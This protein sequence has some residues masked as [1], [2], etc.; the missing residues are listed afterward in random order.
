M[1]GIE[2]LDRQLLDAGSVVG[3]L[4]PE[5]SVHQFLADHRQD[6]FPDMMFEDLFRSPRGRPSVPGSVVATVM[7]L[8][9]LEGLSDR[10]ALGRL[11]WDLR[12]KVAAGLGLCDRGFHHTVLTLWRGKLRKSGTPE[13][14]FDAVRGVINETG[15]LSGRT[16]RVLDST[17][18]DDAVAT[19]DTVTMITAGVRK[20]LRLV[21]AARE[22]SL[23]HGYET[24][25]KP[26]CDWDDPESRSRLVNGLVS[27]GLAVLEAAQDTVL[28]SEQADAV[29]LLGVVVGQDVEPDPD[30]EGKWR[31]TRGVAADRTISV[32]DP[33]SRHGRKTSSQKR[34]GYKAH[35]A[36]EPDTGIITACEITPANVPDGPVGTDL[37]AEEPHSVEVIADSAYGSGENRARLEKAGHTTTVKPRPAYRNPRLGPDQFDR[38]RFVVDPE[39]NRVTCPAGNTVGISPRGQAKFGTVCTECVF[40]SRCTT[41]RGG[42]SFHVGPHYRLL[43]EARQKWKQPETVDRYNRHRPSVERIISWIV[44]RGNRKLRHR[45]IIGNRQQ[46][47]TRAA[48]L[49]LRRLINHSYL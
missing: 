39:R 33:S 47:H 38:D 6:V 35:I 32:V 2:R 41:N 4:V 13:R 9:A 24:G 22:V 14:I 28:N 20:V 43:E 49:N 44:A 11:R 42:R 40:R 45:G 15:L 3:D 26:G 23:S 21:P 17:V 46:L 16:K 25:D 8:Q 48:A 31:I 34:D 30:R 12:W 36:A 18:L 37:L 19:Q 5:G 1:L 7:V 27:D 10:E 29:G